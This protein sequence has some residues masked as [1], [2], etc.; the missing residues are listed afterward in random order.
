MNDTENTFKE[1]AWILSNHISNNQDLLNATEAMMPMVRTTPVRS[2]DGKAVWDGFRWNFEQSH[3]IEVAL[4]NDNI[5]YLM[6][7][8]RKIEAI[9]VLRNMTGCGLKAAKDAVDSYK[10]EMAVS[11]TKFNH[12]E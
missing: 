10:V 1:I 8:G 7:I 11:A 9:K 3:L 12:E 6:S 4:N 2:P 5:I